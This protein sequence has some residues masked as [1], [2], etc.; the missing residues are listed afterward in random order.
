MG[1]LQVDDV[2]RA[3]ISRLRSVV[4]AR[5]ARLEIGIAYDKEGG[6]FL[7]SDL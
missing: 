3:P 6:R 4:T 2:M 5:V 7:M 1:S